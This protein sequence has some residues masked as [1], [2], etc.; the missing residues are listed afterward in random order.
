MV[1]TIQHAE[2]QEQSSDSMLIAQS[3][4]DASHFGVLFDRHADAIYRFAAAR[5]GPT[6]AE[7]VV[8]DVFAIAFDRR[9]TFDPESTSAR[10]W[11]YGIAANCLKKLREDE[12]RWL[13]RSSFAGSTGDD[14]DDADGMVARLDAQRIAPDIARALLTISPRERDVLLLHALEGLSTTE[15]AD[16]L[17]IRHGAA[18]TRLARARTRLRTQL[19][20]DDPGRVAEDA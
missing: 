5:V 12:D 17:G 10:P 1:F 13:K 4:S 11:L 20:E 8:S 15:I 2:A 14:G 7:D 18:R 19:T 9:A 16:A 3:L 6:R